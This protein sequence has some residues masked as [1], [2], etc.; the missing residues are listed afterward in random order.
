METSLRAHG[1]KFLFALTILLSSFLVFQV[2]PLI[3][4]YILP[5]FGGTPGVWTVCMLF[6]QVVLFAGYAYAHWL[7]KTFKPR[8]QFRLH[9]G[10]LL[11]AIF[12][13]P[14]TPS[15]DWK[16][17]GHEDPTWRILGLLTLTVGLPYFLLSST[18][19]LIQGWFGRAT[20]GA[21]PYRLYALS[22]IGS[23]AGL[24][25]YPFVFEPLWSVDTQA[26]TWSIAFKAFAVLCA[27]CALLSLWAPRPASAAVATGDPQPAA[28]GDAS[29]TATAPSWTDRSLWFLLAAAAS[30]MLLATTNQVCLDVAVIPFLWVLPLSLYL[31]TF[32]LCFDREYWYPRKVYAVGLGV[33]M[34]CLVAFLYLG[35]NIG[36]IPQ[37]VVYFFALFV[38]CM[39]C[40]GELVRMKPSHEHLTSFYLATSAGGAAGGLF[41]GLIA[42]LVFQRYIEL[43]IGM[44]L[45]SAVVLAVFFRDKTWVLGGGKPRWV[46]VCLIVG[47]LGLTRLLRAHAGEVLAGEIAVVRN[48]YG[49]LRV[50]ELPD[51]A[52][53]R[54][55]RV[56]IH[57]RILH[58]RQFSEPT[59]TH[60][61]T[62]YYGETAGVGLALEHLR[63]DDVPR[64]V[65]VVGLGVGTLAAYGRPGDV[66]RYYEINPE[67]IRLAREHFT[68]LG[69][70]AAHVDV[71][72]GDARLSLEHEADQEFDLLVLDA[73]SSD[74]IPAHLLTREA[75]ETY[76]RHLK[77]DGVL[78]IHISNRHFDLRPIVQAIGREYGWQTVRIL[79]TAN[80]DR[81]QSRADWMLLT[82]N[83]DFLAFPA[84]RN[85]ITPDAAPVK[86]LELWTDQYSDVVRILK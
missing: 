17:S 60:I 37:V 82:R 52:T 67:V 48:F 71:V 21:S 70:S 4:K 27:G 32:I 30:T 39:V 34:V 81:G 46:W 28:T 73:F 62:A 26:A 76:R 10:L 22:N 68:Y 6:F 18:G 5:W 80:D 16:P 20:S 58:G 49:V 69:D 13:L 31:L 12:F 29:R 41:V 7:I 8:Q 66:I 50:A 65:G 86:P 56:M 61:P 24:V 77:P 47:F 78:A 44:L 85:A 35:E 25:T 15:A 14:I 51:A 40:H 74:A 55:S 72:L 1:T 64:R 38:C 59:Q 53:G 33:S 57:G 9:V 83:A 42:P 75:C 54:P 79:S 43:H 36:I 84:V 63:G 19:P 11:V 2:Q 3:S 45:C 23:I